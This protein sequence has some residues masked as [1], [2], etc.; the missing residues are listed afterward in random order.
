MNLVNLVIQLIGGVTGAQS[1]TAIFKQ[2]SSGP[3][4]DTIIGLIGGFA[5]GQLAGLIPE[6]EGSGIVPVIGNLI[7]G[8]LGGGVLT[9]LVGFIRQA[10][11]K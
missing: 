7:G 1:I 4:L 5:G 9:A 3:T 10:L 8:G 11:K 6:L 2:F